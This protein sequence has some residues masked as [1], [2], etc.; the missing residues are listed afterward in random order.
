MTWILKPGHWTIEE[1]IPCEKCGKAFLPGDV[2]DLH[3]P[4]PDPEDSRI[5]ASSKLSHVACAVSIITAVDEISAR[6]SPEI[7]AGRE[8]AKAARALVVETHRYFPEYQPR[9]PQETAALA[10]LEKA[11]GAFERARDA[12]TPPRKGS[13]PCLQP[14]AMTTCGY[15][16]VPGTN[17][18]A[19]H[20]HA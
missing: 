9:Q 12:A 6:I 11:L 10:S 20:T 8:L 18:C 17:R 5:E 13:S 7:S 1:K 2:I 14:I 16:S 15:P 3:D 4:K 19:R